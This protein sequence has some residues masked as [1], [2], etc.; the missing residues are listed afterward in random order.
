MCSTEQF[1]HKYTFAVGSIHADLYH[2]QAGE[3]YTF[4]EGA[5]GQLGHN[6]V[7]NELLPR[8]VE[9]IDGPAEKVTCGRY[10]PDNKICTEQICLNRN[11]LLVQTNYMHIYWACA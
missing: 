10:E 9:G 11:N 2:F 1:P 4:G 8:K 7:N 5:H 3:V 6:F